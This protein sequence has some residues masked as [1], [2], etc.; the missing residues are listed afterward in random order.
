M[1]L[2]PPFPLDR[3]RIKARRECPTYRYWHYHK[4]V[5][6]E[7]AAGL[8][9]SFPGYHFAIG[10]VVHKGLE[11][12]LQTGDITAALSACDPELVRY[13]SDK[14]EKFREMEWL[15]KGMVYG[16][17]SQRYHDILS[18]YRVV[19]TER[20]YTWNINRLFNYTF[21]L[22]VLLER[23]DDNRL[24]ILDFKTTKKASYDWAKSFEH[25]LQPML[26]LR[27][28]EEIR[29]I[30]NIVGM[31]FE[32]LVKGDHRV[33]TNKSSPFFGQVIQYSPYCYGYVAPK[34]G[35]IQLDYIKGVPRIA[36]W[37]SGHTIQSWFDEV[38][39]PSKGLYDLFATVPPIR[40]LPTVIDATLASIIETETDFMAR[41]AKV[42]HVRLHYPTLVNVTEDKLFERF[43]ERC[44]KYGQEHPCEFYDLCWTGGVRDN[45]LDHGYIAREPNHEE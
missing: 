2:T 18:N 44:W 15:C 9:K 4:R 6:A 36:A 33:D 10:L 3:S 30:T 13:F 28:L 19:E 45:P 24:V 7:E 21:R 31:Q 39:L 8:Q 41:V 32:G 35:Q 20:T 14:P 17:Y 11:V 16:W 38:I 34:S 22:D 26:Y 40:P 27:A 43:T 25:D 29:G 37:D 5:M 12:L 1:T 23:L 42:E